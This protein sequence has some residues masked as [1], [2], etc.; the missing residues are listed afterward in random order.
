MSAIPF[1]KIRIPPGEETKNM[2]LDILDQTRIH[3]QSYVLALKVASDVINDS[4]QVE[5]YQ[6]YQAVKEVIKNPKKL[7]EIDISQYRQE[8]ERSG[9]GNM[10]SI[11][12]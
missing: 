12:D 4:Q 6:Q 5:K 11:L 9:Q 7:K 1:L 10:T 3:Q 2:V 8:L